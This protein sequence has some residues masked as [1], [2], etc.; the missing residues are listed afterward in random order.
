[1]PNKSKIKGSTFEREVAK[2]LSDLYN[3]SFI[4][5]ANSGAYVGGAN[6]YRVNTLSEGQVQSS[7]G[8]I[9]PPDGWSFFNCECKSYSDFPFHQ[10][11]FQGKIPILEKFISQLMDVA[12]PGDLNLLIMKFNRKGKYV[13]FENNLLNK[14]FKTNR[15]VSYTDEQNNTWAIT[16]YRDFWQ[17]NKNSVQT[18]A[19]TG[20]L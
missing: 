16:G 20:I 12:K 5:V 6:Y 8:D 14:H 3:E 19:N 17:L 18:L 2:D 13:V 9:Q 7:R 15:Y 1:M 4:R 10:L 11:L